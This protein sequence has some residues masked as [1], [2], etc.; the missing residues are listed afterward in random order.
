MSGLVPK[1]LRPT[2]PEPVTGD[3]VRRKLLELLGIEELPETVDFEMSEPTEDEG[4]QLRSVSYGNSLG[5]TVPG[6]LCIPGGD[7]PLPGVVCMPGTG[8]SAEQ[9]TDADFGPEGGGSYRLIGWAREL[10]RRGF[11]TLSISLKGCA[12]RGATSDQWNFQTKLLAPYGVHMM[13]ILVEEA[14]KA[15]R[16]LQILPEVDGDRIGMTGMSLGGNATWYS[17]SCA[18]WIAAAAPVCGGVGSIVS[19]T[20]EGNN[21]RHGSHWYIPNLLRHFDHP[22]VVAACIAPRPLMIVGPT[23]DEDMPRSGVDVLIPVVK[24]AYESAGRPQNFKVH[25]PPGRHV[26]EPRYFEWMADWFKYH[27]MGD[28]S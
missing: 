27:L 7:G 18:P 4:L 11:V 8:G 1:G 16:V 21:E 19:E 10:A 25:Q 24:A 14:L 13:G 15:S 20:H 12:G 22:D 9:L 28:N 23:E 2:Y 26:F 17:T 5:E 6:V 3:D